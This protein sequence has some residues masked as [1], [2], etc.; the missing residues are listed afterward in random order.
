MSKQLYTTSMN[1]KHL[2]ADIFRS[3]SK[4]GIRRMSVF[5]NLL[6]GYSDDRAISQLL[7]AWGPWEVKAYRSSGKFPSSQYYTCKQKGVQL[8]FEGGEVTDSNAQSKPASD[9]SKKWK[10]AAA[11]MY[12]DRIEGFSKF[13]GELGLGLTFDLTN[14]EVALVCWVVVCTAALKSFRSSHGCC[15]VA[16]DQLTGDAGCD[17]AWGALRQGRALRSCV[18]CLC[19][20]WPS[21]TT[22]DN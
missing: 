7:E 4:I 22:P 2:N 15:S 6:G 18:G 20:T 21:G 16:S 3:W 5:K 17:A 19:T 10:F 8:C 1:T 13:E 11:H 12:N 9:P 14:A